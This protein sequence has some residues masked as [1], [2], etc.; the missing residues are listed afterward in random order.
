MRDRKQEFLY[1]RPGKARKL[2][3]KYGLLAV[4]FHPF[5]ERMSDELKAK[6]H[7]A[8]EV[9]TIDSR[10]LAYGNQKHRV[11]RRKDGKVE[12]ELQ[13]NQ[14]ADLAKSVHSGKY[15]VE[16]Q[17]RQNRQQTGSQGSGVGF[18]NEACNRCLEIL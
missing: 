2:P 8:K 5:A 12:C 3:Q 1:C 11:D 18:T 17:Y 16:S 6:G 9:A 7:K 4:D 14:I 10:D 15:P 13:R